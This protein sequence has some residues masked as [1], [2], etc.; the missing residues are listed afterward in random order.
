MTLVSK[1]DL[2]KIG[3]GSSQAT[4]IISQAKKIMVDN[5][6]S[7]YDNRRLGKVPIEVVENILGIKLQ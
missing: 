2:I 6:Y 1:D 4:N 3:L 7:Y 5:G